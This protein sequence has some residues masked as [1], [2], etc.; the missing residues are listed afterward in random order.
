MKYWVQS[1]GALERSQTVR[2]YQREQI[3]SLPRSR[4]GD[5]PGENVEGLGCCETIGLIGEGHGDSVSRGRP[6]FSVH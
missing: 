6:K 5:L 2:N 4:A 1:V 3:D